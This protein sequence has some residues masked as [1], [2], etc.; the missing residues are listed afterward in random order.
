[1]KLLAPSL[2]VYNNV[3]P[4]GKEFIDELNDAMN[5]DIRLNW[6]WARTSG[7]DK[8]S[9]EQGMYR[10]N[11]EF[12]IGHHLGNER[13]KALDTQV[14]EATTKLIS[15]YSEQYG[16]GDLNDEGYNIL[17]YE[18]GTMYKRHHDCGGQHKNRVVSMLLY[19]NDDYEGG[20]LEF[21]HFDVS[22]KPKAGDLVLF[23]SN[24]TFAHTAHPV[25][26]GTKYAIVSW[27]AYGA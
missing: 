8:S 23:P 17:K 11:Q 12:P 16:I 10:T 22:Y 9:N 1:M 19:L 4:N 7:E 14:F 3:F 6:S 2:H 21:P 13:L 15:Q 24:Y 25:T 20:H 27:M 5:E 18:N 26:S